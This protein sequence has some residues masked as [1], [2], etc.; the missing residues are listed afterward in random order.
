MNEADMIGFIKEWGIR[1]DALSDRCSDILFS[2]LA[3]MPN[4]GGMNHPFQFVVHEIH[5]LEGK[6]KI[7]HTKPAAPF[8]R[9]EL[10][11][12]WKKHFSVPH[13][14]LKN[15][16]L[17]ASGIM[18]R[19][20]QTYAED[21]NNAKKNISLSDNPESAARGYAKIIA[22]KFMYALSQRRAKHQETGDYLVYFPHET[23][24]YYLCI[25]RHS[26]DDFIRDCVN[27]CASQ[28]SF[29]QDIFRDQSGSASAGETE[30]LAEAV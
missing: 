19:S 8:R 27:K 12:L 15:N 4:F 28:F 24:N 9:P 21:I 26:Q 29:I 18:G 14:H 22:D 30:K 10:R 1:D 25:A 6:E 11:G 16:A 17:I 13:Y 2:Q 20:S 3:N 23:K 5:F 7:S